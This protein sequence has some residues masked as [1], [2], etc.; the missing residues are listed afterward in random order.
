MKSEKL[1]YEQIWNPNTGLITLLQNG[2]EIDAVK[3][4]R[5]QTGLRTPYQNFYFKN[6]LQYLLEF[7]EVKN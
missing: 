2:F 5:R 1:V 4:D 6:Y 3:G 7:F